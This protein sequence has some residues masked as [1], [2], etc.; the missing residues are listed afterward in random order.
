MI[1]DGPKVRPRPCLAPNEIVAVGCDDDVGAG[2]KRVGSN[3][4]LPWNP[5]TLGR[6]PDPVEDLRSVSRKVASESRRGHTENC[7]PLRN[8]FENTRAELLLAAK[9]DA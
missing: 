5:E 4:R 7:V 6:R 3:L 9:K 2:G 1:A 8:G